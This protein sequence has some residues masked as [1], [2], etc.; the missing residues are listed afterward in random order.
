MYVPLLGQ[1][2]SKSEARIREKNPKNMEIIWR[3]IEENKMWKKNQRDFTG[4]V[5]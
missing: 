4:S 2:Y 5:P 1:L 3:L